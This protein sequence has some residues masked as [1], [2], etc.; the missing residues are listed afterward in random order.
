MRVRKRGQKS[1]RF[2][3]TLCLFV[4]GSKEKSKRKLK[5]GKFVHMWNV[6][7]YLS[8]AW[9]VHEL[10]ETHGDACVESFETMMYVGEMFIPFMAHTEWYDGTGLSAPLCVSVGWMDESITG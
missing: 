2:R 8:C 1:K 7:E 4:Q 6:C 10:E 9:N 3:Q 5:A